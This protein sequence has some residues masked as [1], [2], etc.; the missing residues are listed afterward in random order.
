MKYKLILLI[1]A[2]CLVLLPIVS[3]TDITTCLVITE[4]GS[5]RLA[6]NIYNDEEEY[7]CI[8]INAD[9]VTINGNGYG[10]YN[11]WN[12]NCIYVENRK[13]IN[14][15]GLRCFESYVGVEASEV[16]DIDITNGYFDS[17]DFAGIEFYNVDG[18]YIINNEIIGVDSTNAIDIYN[19]RDG[20]IRTNKLTDSGYSFYFSG[21]SSDI[22]IYNNYI[23]SYYEDLFVA[24]GGRISKI[25]WNY[26]PK[27]LGTNIVGGK[28][29]AGNYWVRGISERCFD[30]NFDGICDDE[31]QYLNRLNQWDKMPLTRVGGLSI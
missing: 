1:V 31:F 2:V 26:S 27:M 3:A 7:S 17:P 20:N 15:K 9:Y 30:G 8:E 25:Q 18:F 19:S 23:D 6:N 16:N 10:I 21:S 22:K 29:I 13:N 14:I 28:Y 4:S 12:E 5:Y 24:R 11:D